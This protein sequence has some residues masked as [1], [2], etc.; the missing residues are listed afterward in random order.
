MPEPRSDNRPSTSRRTP[1]DM[2]NSPPP[3]PY[4]D[5]ILLARHLIHMLGDTE[6]DEMLRVLRDHQRTR[7]AAVTSPVER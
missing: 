4:S 6:L 1:A 3:L 7:D 5:P 2:T